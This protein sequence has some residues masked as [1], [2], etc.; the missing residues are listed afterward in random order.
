MTK[1]T[2]PKDAIS[3]VMDFMNTMQETGLKAMPGFEVAWLETMSNMGSEMLNF[4]AER[5]KSDVQTQHDLLHAKDISDIQ[6][7]QAQFMQRA[8]DDYAAE[9]AKM[10]ELGKDMMP[11]KPDDSD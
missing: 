9:I 6:H 2:K 7:I 11:G 5:V 8:M 3:P 10:T 4:V 1:D